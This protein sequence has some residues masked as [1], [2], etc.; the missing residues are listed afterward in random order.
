MAKFS[1]EFAYSVRNA[2]SVSLEVIAEAEAILTALLERKNAW[3]DMQ[4]TE[5][6]EKLL[7]KDPNFRQSLA[8]TEV[9]MIAHRELTV[10]SLFRDLAVKHGIKLLG[11]D[12]NLY[13]NQMAI[14]DAL[15]QVSHAYAASHSRKDKALVTKKPAF[16]VGNSGQPVFFVFDTAMQ[17][18][19]NTAAMSDIELLFNSSAQNRELG[20]E[21]RKAGKATSQEAAPATDDA[22]KKAAEEAALRAE[23]ERLRAE[24]A[25]LLKRQPIG[26]TATIQ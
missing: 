12:G 14:V 20:R 21:V 13:F 17:Y 5:K 15:A 1:S 7:A 9:V 25:E 22:A 3:F 26:E 11:K 8:W 16:F 10:K 19:D 18:I 2:N 23:V 6:Q 24:Q 4:E